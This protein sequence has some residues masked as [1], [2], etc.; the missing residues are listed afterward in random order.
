MSPA[1]VSAIDRLL[2]AGDAGAPR[3]DARR[4]VVRLVAAAREA[5]DEV[6]T[7]VTAHEIARRAGVG[8]GTFY[9]R[10]GSRQVLL[11]AVLAE[12]L[13]EGIALADEALAEDDAWIGFGR[14]AAGY[15]R[16]RAASCGV[17]EALAGECDL[18]L[19]TPVAATRDRLRRLVERAQSTGAMRPDVSWQDVAFL[20]AGVVPVDHTLGLRPDADQWRR[21]LDLT[22]DGLRLR[23]GSA[24]RR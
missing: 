13:D 15:V 1:P 20:L 10:V 11:E 18:D 19:D 16:L 3:A 23:G 17:N 21:N 7:E 4:N 5:L 2:A 24:G 14:F 6:G 8:V 9:R 22:L 12:L